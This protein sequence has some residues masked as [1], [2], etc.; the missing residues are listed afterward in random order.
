MRLRGLHGGTGPCS[1]NELCGG[2]EPFVRHPAR[3]SERNGGVDAFLLVT[4]S[5]PANEPPERS[6]ASI[7]RPQARSESV[8][9]R[10]AARTAGYS[11]A[12]APTIAA[13]STPAT[14]PAIG[15]ATTHAC[16]VA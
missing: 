11:P 4:A 6:P 10:F 15:I 12:T 8:G 1:R 13:P 2:S 16:E 5:S 14:Q 9:A 7:D 3:Y